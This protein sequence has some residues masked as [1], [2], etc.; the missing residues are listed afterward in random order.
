MEPGAVC[1]VGMYLRKKELFTQRP[2]KTTLMANTKSK[3][4]GKWY[5]YSSTLTEN[6][7][8]HLRKKAN[9]LF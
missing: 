4:E 9:F 7:D 5:K 8:Y 2:R 3:N 6:I 1:I